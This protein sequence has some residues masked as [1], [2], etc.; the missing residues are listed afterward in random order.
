MRV[1]TSMGEAFINAAVKQVQ[2]DKV[3]HEPMNTKNWVA[4]SIIDK[5]LHTTVGT[6]PLNKKP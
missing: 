4:R 5:A 2:R 6:K 1:A 3:A